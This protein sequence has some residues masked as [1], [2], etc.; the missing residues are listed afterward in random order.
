MQRILGIDLGTT[1]SVMAYVRKGRPIIIENRH[2]EELTPSVVGRGKRGELLIGEPAKARAIA[3][4]GNVL[5]SVK[6]FMGRKYSDPTVQ[7]ILSEPKLNFKVSEAPDGDVRLWLAGIEYSPIE[8][9]ALILQRLRQDAEAR[10]GAGDEFG[11]AVITVPAYFGERQV[12]ATYEAG[13]L[14]GF[15][16]LRIINEPTADCFGLRL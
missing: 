7:A 13:E 4:P 2:N 11:R 5:Y 14:A 16:V 3:E 10:V 15:Q 1:N 6:R 9:S 8:I 12:A